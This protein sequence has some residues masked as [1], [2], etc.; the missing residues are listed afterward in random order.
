MLGFA[1]LSWI[2]VSLFAAA[3]LALVVRRWS[4]DVWSMNAA[5]LWGEGWR[6]ASK[7]QSA[8]KVKERPGVESV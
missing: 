7:D 3:E 1:W 5:L 2:T 4:A 8:G 6:G